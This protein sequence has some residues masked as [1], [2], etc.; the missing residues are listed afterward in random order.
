M[1]N[2]LTQLVQ[3]L[4]GNQT[5]Q[6]E[7]TQSC[8]IKTFR[9]SGAK[10]FFNTE[11]RAL[12]WW[13]T[14]VQTRGWAV[15]I[16]QP[17]EDFKKLSMK[18]YCT[19]DE[20]QKLETEFWNHKMVGPDIDGY[21]TRFHELARL[22]QH[23]ENARNNKRSNDQNK[24]QGRDDRNKRKITRR[25]F[26]LTALEQG[27]G[28]RQY[29]RPHP[30]C[31][32]CNFY[33]SGN[34]PMCGRCNQVGHFTRYCMGRA[35]NER[36][37]PTCFECGDPNNFRRKCLWM[38]R[39]TTA[40][41]NRPHPVLA[42]EG[43]PNPGNNRNRAHGRAFALGVVGAP[44]DLNVVIGT[45]SLNNHF[46]TVLFDSGADYSF[47]S[48]NFLPL[49]NMKPSVISPSYEIEIASGLKVVTNMIVQD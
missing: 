44:Q 29:A 35:T 8:N 9:A 15:A 33:Q 32:K 39:A 13:N 6:R 38:N 14:L 40:G 48:T 24:N 46:A 42:M 43:K 23:M 28:Q 17:W 4:R 16:A 27:H 22:V 25:N 49:I 34:C 12:T 20:I 5:N 19:D 26:A 45:C 7:V 31:A 37:R 2:L 41:G 1:R 11:G 36:P 30:K 3:A 10:E 47:I 21:T 18:E